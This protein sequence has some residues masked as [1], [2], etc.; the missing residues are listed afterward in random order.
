M[1][2]IIVNKNEYGKVIGVTLPKKVDG[3]ELKQMVF[4]IRD[5]KGLKALKY[6]LREHYP[7]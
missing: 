3:E 4:A 7:D 5:P 2:K 1:E 6:Y